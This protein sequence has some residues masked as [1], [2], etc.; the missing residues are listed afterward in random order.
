IVQPETPS[1]AS[2]LSRASARP[3][4]SSVILVMV[5][6]TFSRLDKLD[7]PRLEFELRSG[8]CSPPPELQAHSSLDWSDDTGT[9]FSRKWL[10]SRGL[11]EFFTVTIA[12]SG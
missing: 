6:A 9:V 10:N 12:T 11:P 7:K 2:L 5:R 3:L 4:D 1:T 8:S